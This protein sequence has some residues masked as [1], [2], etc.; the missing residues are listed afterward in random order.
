MNPQAQAF[1]P[2]GSTSFFSFGHHFEGT[3][4]ESLSQGVSILKGNEIHVGSRPIEILVPS[5]RDMLMPPECTQPHLK[6]PQGHSP[7][8]NVDPLRE[9]PNNINLFKCERQRKMTPTQELI[10]IFSVYKLQGTEICL[11]KFI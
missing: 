1:F 5:F 2:R 6:Q 11:L 7:G 3:I 10:I 8:S 4:S 9:D